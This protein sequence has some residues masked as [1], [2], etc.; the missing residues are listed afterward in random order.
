MLRIRKHHEFSS[1]YRLAQNCQIYP[2]L[3]VVE[4]AGYA[5]ERIVIH[6]EVGVVWYKVR[7]GRAGQT[8]HGIPLPL[9]L[10]RLAA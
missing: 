4:Y 1:T 7:N 10:P 5:V 3:C 9:P 6:A 8:R 2:E